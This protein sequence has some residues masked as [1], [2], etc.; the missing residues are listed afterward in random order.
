MMKPAGLVIPG[1]D[2][3]PPSAGAQAFSDGDYTPL[4][5]L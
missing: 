2:P 1:G 3:S 5:G 4:A